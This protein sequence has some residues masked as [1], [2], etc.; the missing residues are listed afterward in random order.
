MTQNA[1]DA[2]A[3]LPQ[4]LMAMLTEPMTYELIA[5]DLGVHLT[6]DIMRGA[7]ANA[8]ASVA[9]DEIINASLEASGRLGSMFV[10]SQLLTAIIERTIQ[11]ELVSS[12]TATL[13]KVMAESVDDLMALITMLQI[14]GVFLDVI[15]PDGYNKM[16][17]AE[18]LETIRVT[19]DSQLSGSI[20]EGLYLW[21]IEYRLDYLLQATTDSD[22]YTK[23]S[24]AYTQEYLLALKVNSE[25]QKIDWNPAGV[26]PYKYDDLGKILSKLSNGNVNVAQ[27]IRTHPGFVVS[28][29]LFI[30]I[31]FL[32]L[33]GSKV[34][35]SRPG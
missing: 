31:F 11:K 26:M 2:V 25:G 14:L 17:D 19:F 12:V 4:A 22:T 27:W 21:P 35:S 10:N 13:F 30:V 15:D 23:N 29:F 3:N 32:Y 34:R 8:I 1:S 28:L 7:L 24:L 5:M 16:L 18:M 9:E 20:L 6:A 33:N